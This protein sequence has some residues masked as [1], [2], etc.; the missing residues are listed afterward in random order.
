MPEAALEPFR[1][2]AKDHRPEPQTR[3]EH[4]LHELL[5]ELFV[6]Q[7]VW[8]T[9]IGYHEL[10][11][12]WPDLTDAGRLA[13]IAMLRRAQAVF[14]ELDEGELSADE[15]ID[16]DIVLETIDSMLFDEEILREAT[17]DP[18][19]YVYILGSGLFSLL[20]RE[21]AP[22]AHRGAAFLGRMRRIPE[23]LAAARENLQG[24]AGRPV[25]LL[26]T[27]TALSQLGGV[28]ELIDQAI[29]QAGAQGLEDGRDLRAE[30]EQAAGAARKALKA[31]RTFLDSDVRARAAGEGRLG[32]DLYRQKLR[33]TL[34][35][36]LSPDDLLA[37]ARKDFELVRGELIRR[38]R[39]LWPVWCPGEALPEGPDADSE[40]VRR[41]LDKIGEQHPPAEELLDFCTTEVER[42]QALCRERKIIGLADEP[43]KITWTPVFMRAYGGAFLDSP[44]PLDKGQSSYFWITPPGDDWPPD[45]VESYLREDSN[46]MLQLLSI[47]EAVPGHYLQLAWSNKCP[48]LTRSVF[49]SGMFAEGWAVYIT[50]VMMDLGFGT[51]AALWLVHWKFY[52]RSITNAMIDVL[53]HAKDMTEEEAMD[54]MIRG[55]FQEEQEARQK[56]LR[57]RLTS[58][59]LSTYY[60]GSIEMWDVELEARRRAAT[61]GGVSQMSVPRQRVVGG[62]G[63]TPGFNYR[64]HLESVISHG[65]PPIKYVRRILA[66]AETGDHFGTRSG[67]RFRS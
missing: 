14:S 31:F 1:S 59:Q 7:P 64:Q 29:E 54:L 60:L 67:R 43:L 24:V 36:E 28:T 41:V 30:L 66:D 11:D 61:G 15:Q 37:R 32:P 9:Q 63:H 25:S 26:H 23:V 22:F 2:L 47:H 58:T 17:W 46:R 56:Y 5:D 52:L 62:L 65:T 42:I 40:V 33:H 55:G 21:Y 45:R 57:A 20:A 48:S 8:A 39:E 44:G 10:D 12:R 38:G 19:S 49:S 4:L 50:Q 51:D 16:R 3:Y 34:G 18:L 13:R 27:E 35:S 6:A 53:I